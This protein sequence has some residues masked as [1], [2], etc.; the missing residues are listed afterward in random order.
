MKIMDCPLNGPRNISEFIC[1]GEVREMPDPA[2]CSDGAW[3]DYLFMENNKAGVI[4]EWWCHTPT[5]FWFIARRDTRSEEIIETM[6][7]AEF[8][9]A[10]EGSQP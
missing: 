8:S 9:A 1:G 6:T 7:V 5:T 3:V 4:Y 2:T 10:G